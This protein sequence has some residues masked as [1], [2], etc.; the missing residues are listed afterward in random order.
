MLK[1]NYV[2]QLKT[3]KDLYKDICVVD[4]YAEALRVMLN[5]I[6]VDREN[7]I[8]NKQRICEIMVEVDEE[9]R[10]E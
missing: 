3:N 4:D 10:S 6:D 2:L 7:G 9:E 8:A 1:K 5:N